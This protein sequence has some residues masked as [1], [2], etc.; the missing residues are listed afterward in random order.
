MI[1]RGKLARDVA[2]EISSGSGLEP[3]T[4]IYGVSV[5]RVHEDGTTE[6][7]FD[8]SCC[9]STLDGANE[10]V[11]SLRTIEPAE[12]ARTLRSSPRSCT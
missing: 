2:Y 9:F 11:E 12:P 8:A 10:H 5:V 7:D 4:S 6:R 3:G 1:A